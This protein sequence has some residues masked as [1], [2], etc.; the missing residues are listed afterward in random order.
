MLANTGRANLPAKV[1]RNA[2]DKEGSATLRTVLIASITAAVVSAAAAAG[3]VYWLATSSP[4]LGKPETATQQSAAQT[5]TEP[6]A[7]E[8]ASSPAGIKGEADG[9]VD[10]ANR[11][12]EASAGSDEETVA[13][14]EG[15][16]GAA[17]TGTG[18]GFGEEPA[19]E[20][21]R[22]PDAQEPN[23]GSRAAQPDGENAE[24]AS[25]VMDRAESG[26]DELS[27]PQPRPARETDAMPDE[28]AG[29]GTATDTSPAT[30]QTD[31]EAADKATPSGATDI[32]TPTERP[33]DL[34]APS[35]AATPVETAEELVADNSASPSLA[36]TR[37]PA[38]VS[39]TAE[40]GAAE[41]SPGSDPED[42]SAVR[43]AP[44]VSVSEES[45]DAPAADGSGLQT[46]AA[47]PALIGNLIR[48]PAELDASPDKPVNLELTLAG[49][50]ADLAGHT[51][52]VSGLKRGSRLSAGVELMFDTWRV[53]L[54]DVPGLEA[55][56]PS[57]FARR[58]VLQLQV[59]APD[60]SARE[61]NAMILSMP[62][63]S[64]E[65][66]AD[67]PASAG[68]PESLIRRVD[69]AEIL[70]DNGNLRAAR[71][72]FE[73]AAGEGSARAA[74]LLAASY[75]PRHQAAFAGAAGTPDAAAAR[76][77]YERARE[78]GAPGAE[79]GIEQ[80]PSP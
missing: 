40:E 51:L 38:E 22:A 79:K 69:E 76:R 80:L 63:A 77:W 74:M 72:L 46:L 12:A 24:A 3:T 78:L 75:D 4:F 9:A 70:V 13:A 56:V 55:T 65:V 66:A 44:A 68:L 31:G 52:I 17:T 43:E 20:V 58:M 32:A 59:R 29:E 27:V 7:D 50:S 2:E 30:V 15:E 47:T 6:T 61:V 18:T 57:G 35:D 53:R 45:A 33:R 37:S 64:R 36:P 25:G 10:N 42:V 67:A 49:D 28:T 39:G 41:A 48:H 16:G 34:P 1:E 19:T 54:E 21:A 23:P 73:R 71:L 60:G 14:V 62:G 8:P 11:T 26:A 5:A